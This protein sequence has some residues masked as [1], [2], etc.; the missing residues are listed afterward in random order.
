MH[1]E[2]IAEADP[3]A[4]VEDMAEIMSRPIP[5]APGLLLH[6]EGYETPFYLKD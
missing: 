3:D 4:R 6:A 5:W 2:I 1:D